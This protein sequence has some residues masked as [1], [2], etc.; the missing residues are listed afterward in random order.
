M[1]PKMSKTARVPRDWDDWR[2]PSVD[3]EPGESA[4]GEREGNDLLSQLADDSSL[5]IAWAEVRDA[6]LRDGHLST[7][8]RKFE[9]RA[10]DHLA[11]LRAQLEQGTWLPGP[12]HSFRQT[13][14]GT[15]REFTVSSLRDRIVERAMNEVLSAAVDDT[16]SPF[17]FGFRRGMGVRSALLALR[18]AR[19]SGY[20]HVARGDIR[21]A[22]A[23]VPRQAVV[24]ALGA[25]LPDQRVVRLLERLLARLDNEGLGGTGIPQGSAV[26]PI[27]LNVYLDVIDQRLLAEGFIPIRYADD[28]AV[29]AESEAQAMSILSQVSEWLG[30]LSLELNAEK[31]HVA[32]FEGGVPFLGQRISGLGS[33]ADAPDR[34]H[35]RRIAVYVTGEG[36]WAKLRNGRLRVER[37]GEAIS[38]LPLARVQTLVLGQRAGASGPL[39]RRAV[40]AGT[41][42]VMVDDHGGYVG[43]LGRRRGADVRV[44]AAQF[45]VAEDSEASL[46]LARAMAAAKLRNM[47]IAVLR[48]VRRRK[49]TKAGRTATKVASRLA[50]ASGHAADASSGAALMGMEGAGSRA[51]FGWLADELDDKW[52]FQGRNRRPPRDPIN[53]MLSFGYTLLVGELV[54]AC[55]IAGL[56]PDM[57]FLHSPRWG[58]PSLAL[59]LMEQWRPVL[60]DV[61]VMTLV[62]S[63][64]VEPDDF[65]TDSERGCRMNE[66]SKRAFLVAYEKRLL[67]RASS[68]CVQ[69]RHAYRELLAAH[70]RNLADHL[71]HGDSLK[72]YAWR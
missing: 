22:F 35:P 15:E 34:V 17:S 50:A 42:V 36:A 51:Y 39:L 40:A 29:P 25:R 70:A 1:T 23:S 53:A 72:W 31:S 27:L 4:A 45:R 66:R 69:G 67:T 38:S 8:T 33:P 3:V 32:T 10:L 59:D 61:A 9:R 30:E 18:E 63:G 60:V 14:D 55:E 2:R 41:D 19:D 49:S 48:D 26:S 21:D 54:S 11:E 5:M 64:R 16:L 43:R 47:R 62:R 37:D 58:R 52:Q 6:D 13:I 46:T 24:D 12:T 44:R 56:D 7:T 28:I 71:L 20:S 65:S 68:P 57:G